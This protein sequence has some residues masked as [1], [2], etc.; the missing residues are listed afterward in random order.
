ME[1]VSNDNKRAHC[2]HPSLNAFI[3]SLKLRWKKGKRYQHDDF[4][5][6]IYQSCQEKKKKNCFTSHFLICKCVYITGACSSFSIFFLLYFEI[7]TWNKEEKK[8][9]WIYDYYRNRGW[10]VFERN[11]SMCL[12]NF[13]V[14]KHC[15][16]KNERNYCLVGC[17]LFQTPRI[18]QSA[19]ERERIC[20]SK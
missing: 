13:R 17:E 4:L 16:E 15:K 8:C 2:T 6:W 3:L 19:K 11:L 14:W 1:I 5:V 10:Q 9:N 7:K 20:L 12:W 18:D